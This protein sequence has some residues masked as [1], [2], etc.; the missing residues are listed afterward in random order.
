M[1][2]TL[3]VILIILALVWAPV[4]LKVYCWQEGLIMTVSLI[5]ASWLIDKYILSRKRRKE[6]E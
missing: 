1:V 3:F 4:I 6:S 2:R 5:I